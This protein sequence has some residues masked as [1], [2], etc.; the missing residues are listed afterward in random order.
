[1]NSKPRKKVSSVAARKYNKNLIGDVSILS[2]AVRRLHRSSDILRK[3]SSIHNK[4]NWKI[5]GEIQCTQ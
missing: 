2:S 1:M 3:S 4:Y 5:K